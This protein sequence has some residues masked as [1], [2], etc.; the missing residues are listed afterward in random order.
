MRKSIITSLILFVLALVLYLFFFSKRESKNFTFKEYEDPSIFSKNQSEGHAPI[1]PYTSLEAALAGRRENCEY[2]QSLNGTWKFNWVSKPKEASSDFFTEGFEASNWDDI[3]VPAHWQM[4]GFGHPKFRNIALPISTEP[5]GVPKDYNPVG[6]Y[7]RTFQIPENWSDREVFLRFAGVTS[8]AYIWVNGKEVGYSQGGVAPVEFNV[9]PYLRS[10]NNTLAVRVYRFSDGTYLENMDMWHLSG[11]FREVT[12]FAAPKLHLRDYYIS[13]DLD[14]NYQHADLKVWVDLANYGLQEY[15]GIKVRLN[16][17]DQSG[18]RILA[19]PLE[20]P[21]PDIAIGETDSLVFISRVEDPLKWSAEAPNL[22]RLSLELLDNNGGTIEAYSPNVGFKKVEIIGN[23]IFINGAAVKFNGVNSV[24]H[25]PLHGKAVP[26][27]TIIKDFTLMKQ[28][29]INLVRTSHYPP[30]QE[31]LDLADQFGIYIVNEAELECHSFLHLSND[32]LWKPAFLDRGRRMVLHD[33]NHP[34]IVFWSAGNES[35][36]G[37]NFKYVIE[38]GKKLDPARPFWMYG[39]NVFLIPYEDIVGPRYWKPFQLKELAEQ[40]PAKDSRP[41]FMDEYLCASG[42]GLGGL[43]EYWDLIYRYPRLS[44]GAIWDWVGPGMKVPV[45]LLSNDAPGAAQTAILGN[46]QLTK[47]KVGKGIYLSGHDEWVQVYRDKAFDTVEQLTLE[48]WV[49]P[50]GYFQANSFITKGDH[51]FG[52]IQKKKGHLELYITTEK[53]ERRLPNEEYRP[54]VRPIRRKTS[55]TVVKARVPLNWSKKWHHLVGT[56]DGKSLTLYIDGKN[57]GS[58]KCEGSIVTGNFPVNLG[59]NASLH[60]SHYNGMLAQSYMDGVR[61]YQRAFS[62]EDLENLDQET[63][64][65]ES[66]LWLD[67]EE[68]QKAGKFFWTGLMGDTYG[69]IWPDREIQPELWQLKKSAQPVKVEALDIEKGTLKITNRFHFTNLNEL[70][71]R[72]QLQGAQNV[73]QRGTLSFGLAPGG[74]H[75]LQIPY[76]TPSS[77]DRNN[78]Q[79]LVSFHLKEDKL[80]AEKGHEV[81]W[82]QLALPVAKHFNPIAAN[83]FQKIEIDELP[84]AVL[85]KGSDFHYNFDKATGKLQSMSA[86]GSELVKQGPQ[87]NFWRA[88]ITNDINSWAPW[89]HSKAYETK[90]EHISNEDYWR[91]FGIN[92]MQHQVDDFEVL[93]INESTVAVNI[94]ANAKTPDRLCVFDIHYKYLITGNGKVRLETIVIPEGLPPTWLPKVGLKW[95]LPESLNSL[96]WYGRGPFETY[97][98]RKTGAKIGTYSGKVSGEYVPYLI[99][100]DYGN[101][102]DV[103]SLSLRDQRGKGLAFTFPEPMN[104]S[105]HEYSLDHLDRA[106]YPFQLK[107]SGF[108]TLNTDYRVSGVGDTAWSTLEKYRVTATSYRFVIEFSPLL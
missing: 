33:R 26:T 90:V 78:Y 73:L 100:Q 17:L 86:G 31:Y 94:R 59:R 30:S 5:P 24:M 48:C 22:Y 60:D 13:T 67:F 51:Q 41:S 61:I 16:L 25:H 105:V 93:R 55:K 6:S 72:W 97:P 80:W 92:N 77:T 28:F 23:A 103:H 11:I 79:L 52:L 64:K 107:K 70:E 40:D 87:V 12:L 46:A 101:K 62:P 95:E 49:K 32:P 88:P 82:E 54:I 29:N 108:I 10:G 18:N 20:Q 96:E 84:T 27:E 53:T 85:I 66:L 56:Y 50:E 57:V 91:R 76:Q 45:R 35:G 14:E 37:N 8:A 102:T 39:A 106:L 36:T 34:S 104:F 21:V 7:L 1:V 81:A 74:Q 89:M 15:S 71:C 4:E 58:E 69:M 99:P 19:E 44:G 65:Q 75:V 68:E 98:D 9:T 43:D 63:L 3:R 47:G 2:F 38:Q 42:N 83:T